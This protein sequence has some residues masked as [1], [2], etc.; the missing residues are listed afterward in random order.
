MSR[1]VY[2]CSSCGEHVILLDSPLYN[3]PLRPVDQAYVIDE[4]Q[5][6]FKSS[7][8]DGETVY[9]KRA[10]GY[11]KQLRLKCPNCAVPIAYHQNSR[12]VYVLK[13]AVNLSPQEH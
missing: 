4:D 1:K 6:L 3:A 11:E 13:D 8:E 7:L 9:I 10:K 5:K 12:F 2:H